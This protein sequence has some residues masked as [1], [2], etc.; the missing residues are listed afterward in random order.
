VASGQVLFGDEANQNPK[1]DPYVVL[2]LH[3]AFWITPRVQVFGLVENVF[4]NRYETFGTFSPTSDVPMTEV[5]GASNPRSLS[6]A[7]PIAGFGGVR[8][9]F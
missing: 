8:V 3:T 6:P 9:L 5:P 7:P 4:N 2:N 1:T